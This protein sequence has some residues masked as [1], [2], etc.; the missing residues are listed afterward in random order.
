MPIIRVRYA[1][2]LRNRVAQLRVR[3]RGPY[4]GN[5]V[6]TQISIAFYV[7]T[8][9]NSRALYDLYNLLSIIVSDT[10]SKIR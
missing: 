1:G 3:Q 8:P 4:M 7:Y 5:E 9:V 2:V 6:V 10:L